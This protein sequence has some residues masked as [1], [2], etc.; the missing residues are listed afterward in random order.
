[1]EAGASKRHGQAT[2]DMIRTYSF[3]GTHSVG[4]GLAFRPSRA[5]K[6]ARLTRHDRGVQLDGGTFT[7][8]KPAGHGFWAL[9][10]GARA[11]GTAHPEDVMDE[12]G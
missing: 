2:G 7:R 4:T 9:V 1:M 10:I 12:R 11:G 5:E 3:G 6:R 8:K